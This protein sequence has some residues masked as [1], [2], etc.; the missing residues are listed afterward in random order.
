[1]YVYISFCLCL[2]MMTCLRVCVC[3]FVRSA[4]M[5]AFPSVWVSPGGHLDVGES[6]SAAGLREVQEETGVVVDP[7]TVS[8]LC[9][10]ESNFPI[11][12]TPIRQHVVL[13]F[14]GL[15][16]CMIVCCS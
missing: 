10:W 7:S 3:G 2:C 9:G 12:A 14:T 8:F 11:D 6:L 1:M 5:R 4:S 13:D 16:E 15:S